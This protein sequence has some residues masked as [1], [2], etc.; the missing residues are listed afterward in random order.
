MAPS[1]RLSPYVEQLLDNEDVQANVRRAIV[2]AEQAFG[3]ASKRKTTKEALKDRGVQVRARQ[4]IEAARD[5]I[6]TIARGPQIERAKAQARRRRQRR[7]RVVL[8]MALAGGAYAVHKASAP[9]QD[10][11]GPSESTNGPPKTASA[12]V[13][14][15]RADV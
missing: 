7:N 12:V 3:R 6:T 2:R 14:K 13:E 1:E 11:T 8:L 5:A 15:E 10:A 4:S 9:S